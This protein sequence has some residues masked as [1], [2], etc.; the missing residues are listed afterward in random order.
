LNGAVKVVRERCYE[1]FGRV[2]GELG[3]RIREGTERIIGKRRATE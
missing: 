2:D 1:M 3:R